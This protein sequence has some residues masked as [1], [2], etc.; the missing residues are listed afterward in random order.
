MVNEL[1]FLL[2]LWEKVAIG[3]LR[4]PFF[5]RPPMPCIGYAQSVPD[6]ESFSADEG[7]SSAE[8]ETPHPDRKSDP[9]SPTR[10]E[11]DRRCSANST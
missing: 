5:S 1:S 8:R 2:P 11:V 9:T 10:G 7:F 4:P 6:E 3:G